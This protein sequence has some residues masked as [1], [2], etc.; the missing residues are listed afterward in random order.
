MT[1]FSALVITGFVLIV[2]SCIP[3]ERN[4]SIQ[5]SFER[6]AEEIRKSILPDRRIG[7]FNFIKDDAGVITAFE[8]D[9]P[10]AITRID[11]LFDAYG[12]SSIPIH[13]LPDPALGDTIH[14]VV[15][16][17]VA[18]MRR[19]PR[20]GAELVDQTISGTPLKILKYQGGWV[21]IQTPHQY[22]G[23]ITADSVVPMDANAFVQ[24]Q[25]EPKIQVKSVLSGVYERMDEASLKLS[26]LSMNALLG[27]INQSGNWT[28]V[29]LPD[30]RTG[31]VPASD[32]GEPVKPADIAPEGWEIVQT[33]TKF[34]GIPYLW[35]GNSSRG[36]DC[37]G[38][39]QTVYAANGYQLPRDASMQVEI[40]TD[41]PYDSTFS[42]VVPGDLLFFGDSDRITHV[43]ISLGGPRF[44]HASTYV[45]MN[46]LDPADDNF[47]EYRKRTLK[48]IKRIETKTENL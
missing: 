24:W 12:L 17:G 22:L 37:S 14:A 27:F 13:T 11:S 40:G 4:A 47:S 7:V 30:G 31:F 35:G 36:L 1:R 46:S 45:M 43:A 44:I 42:N 26:D 28:E 2:S 5:A 3:A 23:W 25:A 48:R 6:E 15:R 20:H 10:D 29:R 32:L 19:D 39:T 34:H 9:Q 8:T 16:V 21:Y 18:N 38:Y 33:S 41:V